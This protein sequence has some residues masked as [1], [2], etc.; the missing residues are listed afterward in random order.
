MCI[1]DRARVWETIVYGRYDPSRGQTPTS[2]FL[3]H[4]CRARYLD[5][6][7]DD[8]YVVEVLS[9]HFPETVSLAQLASQAHTI[10][11]MTL[12]LTDYAVSYTHLDVYKRQGIRGRCFSSARIVPTI[13]YGLPYPCLDGS[14]PIFILVAFHKF[15]VAIQGVSHG[16]PPIILHFMEPLV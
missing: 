14:C 12:L 4:I 8:R 9:H 15:L 6:P 1:R 3:A 2:Y 10:E 5:P 11:A 16:I 7:M 13:Y